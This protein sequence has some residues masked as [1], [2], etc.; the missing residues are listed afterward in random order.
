LFE[1]LWGNQRRYCRL[2]TDDDNRALV[3]HHY[4]WFLATYD[5]MALNVSRADAARYLYMHK[6]GGGVLLPSN[7]AQQ[8]LLAH[9]AYCG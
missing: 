7:E 5:A 6:Y 3:Q 8:T 9:S 2:W 4:P 1:E